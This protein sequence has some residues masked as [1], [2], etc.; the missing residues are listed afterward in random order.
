MKKKTYFS[1]FSI[2]QLGSAA[3]LAFISYLFIANKKEQCHEMDIF[4]EGLYI[5]INTFCVC[6][7][8]FPGLSKA[9]HPLQ[10]LTFYLLH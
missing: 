6:A 7:D 5:L 1:G 3:L 9:L 4:F 2:D 8:D 10:L